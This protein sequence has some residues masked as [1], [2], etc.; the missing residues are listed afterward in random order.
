MTNTC[1]SCTHYKPSHIY[2]MACFRT[3]LFA[4]GRKIEAT[5]DIGFATEY[6]ANVPTLYEGRLDGDCCGIERIHWRAA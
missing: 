2:K 4:S 1:T 5:S 6:E 3:K